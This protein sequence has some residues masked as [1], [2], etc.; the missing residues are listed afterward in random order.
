VSVALVIQLQC[1]EMCIPMKLTK[2]VAAAT[3]VACL[4]IGGGSAFA[5]FT[6]TS[7]SA[8]NTAGVS[9]SGTGG[10]VTVSVDAFTAPSIGGTSTVTL[11][12]QQVESGA[13]TINDK[14][15]LTV[16]VDAV[17]STCPSG[18]F[19]LGTPTWK[20]ADGTTTAFPIVVGAGTA[21]QEL[22]TVPLTFNNLSGED[23]EACKGATLTVTFEVK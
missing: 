12:A 7:N 9:S 2:K 23:Q 18:S 19:T 22:G 1:L 11:K 15:T 16:G 17:H 13:V 4:A 6:V 10:S 14:K 20:K 5:Y 3:A 21:L 8:T